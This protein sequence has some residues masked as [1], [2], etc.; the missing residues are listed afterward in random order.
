MR[1]EQDWIIPDADYKNI[2]TT[3]EEENKSDSEPE[4]T[5]ISKDGLVAQTYKDENFL[6]EKA[7]IEEDVARA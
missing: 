4:E 2:Y 5:R 1:K 7:T 3:E 6:R